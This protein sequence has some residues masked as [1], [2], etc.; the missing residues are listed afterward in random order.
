MV[1]QKEKK[2]KK[3]AVAA[4]L[5][6][7]PFGI[8]DVIIYIIMGLLVATMLIP[9]MN[10]VAISLSG[11]EAAVS[12]TS[13]LIPE[14]LTFSAYEILLKPE[15]YRA[16]G[17]TAFVTLANT[18]LHIVLCMMMAYP[19]TQ[20]K[21]PGRKFLMTLVLI[22]MLFNGGTIPMYILYKEL[23]LADNILVY[24][25]PGVVSGFTVVLMRNFISQI[26]E[27]LEEAALLDGA[28]YWQILWRVV[29]PLSKPIIATMALFNA[30][31]VWNNW[32]TG[33]LFIRNDKLKL[34]QNVLRDML[35]EGNMG[36]FG[37]LTQQQSYEV[38]VQMAAIIISIIPIFAVYPFIQRYFI[39]GMHIG[40][41]KG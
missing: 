27:S 20:K 22:P 38:S 1:M 23:G 11:Y 40:A 4:T 13:M 15:V 9:F 12:N 21:L 37:A 19:L 28:N 36:A 29:I 32:F 5:G 35:I 33:V 14:D 30:V 8:A 7:E 39:K 16:L 6:R 24:I 26:P 17:V 10:I 3:K 2:K 25:L 34:I 18:T 31:G 41:V